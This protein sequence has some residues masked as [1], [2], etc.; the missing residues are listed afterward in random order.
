MS[1]LC[2]V[3]AKAMDLVEQVDKNLDGNTKKLRWDV[4]A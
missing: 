4:T 2:D 3:I 1:G